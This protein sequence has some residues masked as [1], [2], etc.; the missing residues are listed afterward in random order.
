LDWNWIGLGFL[1]VAAVVAF[2]LIR[3]LNRVSRTIGNLETFLTSIEKEIT[4][5][6]RN[7]KETSESVNCLLAQA[8]E[9]LNQIEGLFRTLRE[10][11]QTVAA[12]NRILRGGVATAMINLA[13][14]AVGVKTAGYTFF[15]KK[16]KGGK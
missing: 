3:T 8:Q 6:V 4:P 5:M 7:L 11:A 16:E 9:R 15:K 13:G 14:L 2:F 10:S 1:I 12:I